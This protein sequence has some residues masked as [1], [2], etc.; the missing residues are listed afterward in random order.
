MSDRVCPVCLE[1]QLLRPDGTIAT[2]KGAT[3]RWTGR[4]WF[5]TTCRGTGMRPVEATT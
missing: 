5:R 3:M 1:F 4:R 2:H